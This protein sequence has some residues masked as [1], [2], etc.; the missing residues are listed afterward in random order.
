MPLRDDELFFRKD[1]L[2]Y[3][4]THESGRPSDGSTCKN[5]FHSYFVRVTAEGCGAVGEAVTSQTKAFR[6]RYISDNGKHYV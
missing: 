5:V 3:A 6:A 4:H 1:T 2:V